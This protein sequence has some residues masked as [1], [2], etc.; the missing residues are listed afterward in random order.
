M[1]SLAKMLLYIL[2]AAIAVAACLG[3][4]AIIF[5][6]FGWL[7]LRILLTALNVSGASICGLACAAYW[8]RGKSLVVGPLGL[9]LTV[10]GAT[11]VAYLTWI[12]S[13]DATMG[14]L[15]VTVLLLAIAS[16]HVSLLSLARL[17][18]SYAWIR[19]LYYLLVYGLACILIAIVWGEANLAADTARLLGVVAVAVA[20]VT[21]LVPVFH[22]LSRS[23]LPAEVSRVSDSPKI[24]CPTCGSQTESGSGEVKC[25][26]CGTVF[27]YKVVRDVNEGGP[28]ESGLDLWNDIQ[29]RVLDRWGMPAKPSDKKAAGLASS[30]ASVVST[31]AGAP[32]QVLPPGAVTRPRT[33][34]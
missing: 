12:G 34:T 20:G 23:H 18:P 22:L 19:P 11:L 30:A 14:S 15:T 33:R 1:P 5:G 9:V 24:F 3:A 13:D 32:G 28:A 26:S 10:A 31:D 25:A 7:E 21:T 27:R 2:A 16:A 6:S 4:V 8:E 17:A 29:G